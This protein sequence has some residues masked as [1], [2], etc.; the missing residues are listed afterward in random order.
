[1]PVASGAG[2][3]QGFE[4]FV[5]VKRDY[6]DGERVAEAF[7]GLLAG[8]GGDERPLFLLAHLADPHEPYRSFE[9]RRLSL[10]ASL[11]GVELERLDPRGAPHLRRVLDLEAGRHELVL[12]DS[13]ADFVPRSLYLHE[14]GDGERSRIPARWVEGARLA[15]GRRAVVEFELAAPARVELESWLTDHPDQDEAARRYQAEVA[16]ADAAVGEILAALEARGLFDDALIVFTSDHGE[17]FGEHGLNGHSHNLYDELLRVPTIVKL[18]A[19]ARFDAARARLAEQADEL[20]RHVDLA[21]TLLELLELEPLPG[22]VGSSLLDEDRPA[23]VHF[24][25]THR[26]EAAE[27]QLAL[28][29]GRWK[30][31][32]W[33]AAGRFELYDLATDPGEGR[34]LFARRGGDF[35][36]WRAALEERAAAWEREAQDGGLADL[37]A[38]GY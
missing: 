28:T 9:G 1:M 37:G 24:A 23:P 13:G 11:D 6:A 4:R 5:R 32:H 18:P 16:R 21:P 22:A 14:L 34:D 33:P 15:S 8:A 7:E 3:D 31:I 17:A 29:D 12:E 35:D 27:D 26:P 10:T 2:V 38:L 25:E 20:V 30:L 19:D 36:A